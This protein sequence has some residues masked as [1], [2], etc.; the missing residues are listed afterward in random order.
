MDS[1]DFSNRYFRKGAGAT[2]E[3]GEYEDGTFKVV[4]KPWVFNVWKWDDFYKA[5][6]RPNTL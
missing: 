5:L 4:E 3:E 2:G 1:F 6:T